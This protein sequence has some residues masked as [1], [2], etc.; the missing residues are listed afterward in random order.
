MDIIRDLLIALSLA[1]DSAAVS[2]V[3]GAGAADRAKAALLAASFFGFFQAAMFAVGAAGGAALESAVAD[4]DHWVA[5][6]ILAFIGG[7]M[8]LESFRK[9]ERRRLDLF[10]P[11]ALVAMSFATSI[12]ALGVGAGMAFAGDSLFGTALMVGAVAAAA[13]CVMVFAGGTHGAALGKR[14]ELAGGLVLI[15]VGLNIVISHGA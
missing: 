4:I 15:A 2:A 14:M 9:E 11:E 13:S 6:G 8:T 12:D 1:M 7:R 3:W 10:R 5:F